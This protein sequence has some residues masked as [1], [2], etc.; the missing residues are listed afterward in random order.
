MNFVAGINNGN[1]GLYWLHKINDKFPDVPVV[2]FTAYADVELA[3]QAMKDGAFDFVEKP[4]DNARLID[5]LTRAV[6][7]RLESAPANP[8]PTEMVWGQ[9]E[10]MLR[11]KTL[12]EKV[13]RT[14]ANV[15][16][17]GENGTGKDV[18]AHELHRLSARVAKPMVCVDMGAITDTLFESELFGHVKGAFTDARTDRKGLIEEA[19]GGTLFLDEI[20]NLPLHQQAKLLTVVQR[21]YVQRVGSNTPTTVDI[22]LVCAT[23]KNLQNMRLS[24]DLIR[25]RRD[26]LTVCASADGELGQ[27]S[28]ELGQTIASGQM[29]GRINVV[30]GHKM[31]ADIDEHYIDRIATGLTG[32][33]ERGKSTYQVMVGKVYPD[34]RDS[35]FRIDMQFVGN[36]PAN[37]RNGQTNYVNLRLGEPSTAIMIPRGSFFTT[38]GGNWIF[39]IGKDGKTAHRRSVRIGRQN[40]SFYEVTE[41]LQPGERVVI[42]GYDNFGDCTKLIIE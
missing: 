10:A 33:M 20:G 32:T 38:T 9:S 34:V 16:I 3:V 13:A 22:R 21:R 42:G 12:V 39:V 11:L 28:L 8:A 23:N 24:L 15:L 37:M 14:D 2:L 19:D 29:I 25:Q 35:K 1:E 5:T 40:P 36:V 18:L 6:K 17:T 26:K 41:G 4:W 30:N 27:M 7:S 31:E